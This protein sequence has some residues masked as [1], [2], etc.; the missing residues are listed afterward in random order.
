METHQ[1]PLKMEKRQ[2]ERLQELADKERR[3]LNQT[4]LLI[5]D[6][7]LGNVKNAGKKD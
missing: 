6:D 1:Y 7:Y 5:I 2:R 3:S 4:I